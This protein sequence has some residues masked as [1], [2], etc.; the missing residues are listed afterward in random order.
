MRPEERALVETHPREPAYLAAWRQYH[1][2]DGV[3]DHEAGVMAKIGAR[4]AS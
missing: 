3:K 2:T 4:A 1:L